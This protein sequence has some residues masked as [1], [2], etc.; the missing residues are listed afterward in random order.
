[1]PHPLTE[2]VFACLWLESEDPD[3]HI[4]DTH[5][6]LA[7]LREKKT[8]ECLSSL[9]SEQWCCPVCGVLHGEPC[10]DCG[11]RAH[12]VDSCPVMVANSDPR[13]MA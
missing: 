2:A 5:C 9:D 3:E 8:T 6:R 12:H 13:G 7:M 1:M 11:A 10:P 4:T